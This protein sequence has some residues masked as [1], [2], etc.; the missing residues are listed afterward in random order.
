MIMKLSR[1]AHTF[2]LSFILVWRCM[3]I[4]KLLY[5]LSHF[6]TNRQVQIGLGSFKS[7]LVSYIPSRKGHL[8]RL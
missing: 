3:V 2:P 8:S 6:S 5:N 1:I 7:F 4:S